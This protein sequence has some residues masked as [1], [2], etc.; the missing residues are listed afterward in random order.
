MDGS[1]ARFDSPITRTPNVCGGSACIRN[2]RIPVW[3]LVV[4]RT[5]GASDQRLLKMYPT[6]TTDDLSAAWNY[7]AAHREEID[8]DIRSNDD[9]AYVL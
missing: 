1:T 3:S 9:A 8:A 7:Q 5:Q 6:I 4:W 2:T